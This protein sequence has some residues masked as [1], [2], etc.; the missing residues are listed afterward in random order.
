[1][2]ACRHPCFNLLGNDSSDAR[3]PCANLGASPIIA[4]SHPPFSNNAGTT[5]GE[6]ACPSFYRLHSRSV[7]PL[8]RRRRWRRRPRLRQPR[9]TDAPPVRA[10][11]GGNASSNSAP[12][13]SQRPANCGSAG[14]LAGRSRARRDSKCASRKSAHKDA[15]ESVLARSGRAILIAPILIAS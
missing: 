1:M 14:L 11:S 4:P 12:P 2:P 8:S 6:P 13:A 10:T 3:T 15:A 7:S 5:G 9:Q